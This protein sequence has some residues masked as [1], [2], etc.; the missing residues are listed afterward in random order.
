MRL[1]FVNR[2]YW[3][4]EP[5]TAQLL[6]DLAEGLA[7]RGWPVTVVTSHPGRPD[8]PSAE[9]RHGVHIHRVRGPRW[10]RTSLPGRIADF[11][12]FLFGAQSWLLR[13]LAADDLVIAK[14]DPPMLGT[15]L[16]PVIALRRGRLLH[17]A[18]DIYPEVAMALTPWAPLRGLLGLLRLPRNLSW[19]QSCGCVTLGRDMRALITGN[20]VD[21]LRVTVI[22]NWAP[23]GLEPAAA[24]AVQAQR[25]AWGLDQAFVVQYS[26]NLGRVHDLDP[27]LAVAE[28]LRH[29]PGI[30]FVFVGG[31]ARRSALERQARS[32][33][34]PNVRFFPAQPR[35]RLAASLSA[36][37]LHVVTLHPDCAP[38]VFPSKVYG[39]AAV[40]RPLLFIGPAACELADLVREHDLGFAFP[41]SATPAMAEAILALAG[42]S[43]RRAALA[44]HARQFGLAASLPRAVDQWEQRLAHLLPPPPPVRSRA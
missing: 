40:G 19:R 16:W 18:Q 29:E 41:R 10:G 32:R 39:I 24:A 6:T 23:T 43:H 42:D 34:L 27:L 22:P 44:A 4:E 11:A 37:D 25:A 12:A 36:G 31:G 5:A 8:L 9:M 15:W 7:A 17:W 2:F 38:T 3:P 21:P 28:E 30:V 13:H 35:E 33:E 20:G 14:T 26:G 1:I